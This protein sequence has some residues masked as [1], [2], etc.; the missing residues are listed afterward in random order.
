MLAG[1]FTF[2][3]LVI[4]GPAQA[5]DTGVWERVALC[6]SS[7]NWAI[8]NGNGFY[9]GLQFTPSTW[10]GFGGAEYAARADL[11]SKDEQI[12]VARRVLNSQGPGAWPVCSVKAG[13]TRENGGADANAVPASVSRSST[14]TVAATPAAST[15]W[16]ADVEPGADANM[17]LSTTQALQAWVGADVDGIIGPQTSNALQAKVG[18]PQTG[19]IDETTVRKLQELVGADVDGDWGPQTTR[20]LQAYLDA[21]L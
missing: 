7:G 9:G 17:S 15:A 21:V 18:A 6:E 13:L 10:A 14:R 19:R 3:S 5:W 1:A 16:V 2:A 4:P 20:C 11:A 12:A 8:N